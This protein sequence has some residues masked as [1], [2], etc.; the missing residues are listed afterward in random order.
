[1]KK[2]E[3]IFL[4]L[5]GSLITDKARASTAILD[6]IE[7]IADEISACLVK[8][9][10][11]QLVIGHG[12]GSFGHTAASQFQT[13]KGGNSA[14]YWQG[15]AKVWQSARQLNNIV[16]DKLSQSGLP[17]IAFPPSSGV[18]SN[19]QEII[20]WDLQPIRSAL[21]Q[22]LIPVV[23]GDVVFDTFLGG[24]I[25]STEAIFQYLAGKL[26]PDRILLAGLDPGVY[27]DPSNP[28]QIIPQITPEN[29]AE[30]HPALSGAKAAD[31]T[32]GMVSKVNLMLSILE[33]LPTTQVQVFSGLIP[34]NI[35]KS[36][37]G[38][39]LGTAISANS[40]D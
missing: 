39:A 4:K 28:D 1:M 13:Q 11:I 17:V 21:S 9:S 19:N 35:H 31:V 37:E 20:H 38:E 29:Y 27:L 25:L 26:S 10:H 14:E 16:I 30:I 36:L 18:V 8:N 24:T 23:Q 12:S 32:G 6:I 34:G 3:L 7:R 33:S 15:F 5:G 22:Q 2:N 40:Q